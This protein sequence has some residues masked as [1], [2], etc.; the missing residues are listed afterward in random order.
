ML[1]HRRLRSAGTSRSIVTQVCLNHS[2]SQ[3]NSTP[4]AAPAAR[5]SRVSRTSISAI[6]RSSCPPW[7]SPSV[8]KCDT[9][10]EEGTPY[11]AIRSGRPARSEE[12]TSELQ[13]LAYLV[14]RL[15][16]E[17]KKKKIYDGHHMEQ[18]THITQ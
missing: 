4:P 13:S 2:S 15:L 3:A 7:P 10:R 17:K 11:S 6:A 16:L 8:C 5:T 12:H 18:C 1:C 14:C 9:P